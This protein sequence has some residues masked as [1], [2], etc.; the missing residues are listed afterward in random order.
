MLPLISALQTI[1]P[2]LLGIWLAPFVVIGIKMMRRPRA[3][4]LDEFPYL[5]NRDFFSPAQR[6]LLGLLEKALGADFRIFAKVRAQDVISVRPLTDEN[7]WA[8]ALD[9]ISAKYFDFVI[10]DK[11]YL[12][13][14]CVLELNDW[15]WGCE[16]HQEPD[17]FLEHLCRVLGLPFV[18]VQSAADLSVSE[19]KKKVLTALSRDASELVSAEQPFSVGLGAKPAMAERPW[20]MDESRLLEDD[21][22]RFQ[23]RRT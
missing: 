20:T 16:A 22:G 4:R 12:S 23:I 1:L 15:S 14:R 13:V 7:A 3:D 21:L 17:L 11:D 5:K 6:S 18:R 9:Q 10:C 8:G 19:L 2:Y